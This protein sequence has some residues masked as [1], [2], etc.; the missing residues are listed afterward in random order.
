MV[1]LECLDGPEGCAGEVEYRTTPD[2]S[3][4]RGFPRCETHFE[5][6]LEQAE[7]NLELLS[8]TPPSW[9]DPMD[10]GEAWGEDDY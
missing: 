6:R 4:F 7:H 8:S 9:F 3:D 10:A 1:E 2:R 5:R